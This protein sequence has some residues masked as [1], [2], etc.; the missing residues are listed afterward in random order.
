M[1]LKSDIQSAITGD[2]IDDPQTLLTYSKDASIFEITPQI[3]ICPKD[4]ADIKAVIKLV[5]QNPNQHCS[6]TVRA[7]GTDMG[8]GAINDSIILD[9]KY[10]NKIIKVGDNGA[11]TQPGVFYKDFENQTLAQDLLLP[12][13]TAS[14]ELNT[15]GGMVA[16]NSAGEKTLLYGQTEKYV[17]SLK[18]VL[19]DGEEYTFKPLDKKN[20]KTKLAQTDFEGEI[21]RKIYQL[22]DK[23]YDLIKSAKPIVSKNSTGYL[24]W[25]VW[26]KTTFDLS[27]LFVGS[28]GTLGIITEITFRLTHPKKHSRMLVIFMKDLGELAEVVNCI[29]EFQPESFEAYDDNTLKVVARFLPEVLKVFKASNLLSL[30]VSFLPEMWMSITGGFPKLVLL[31]EFTGNSEPEVLTKCQAAQTALKRY[32]LQ[33]RITSSPDDSKKYWTIRRESFNLLRHHSL[34]FKTAPFID[35]IIVNPKDL[36]V[37]LPALR[38]IL[39]QYN[40][41]YTIAT[42]IGNGNFHIIPLMNFSDPKTKQVIPELGQ[43]VY[44]LVFKFK[45]SMSAEHNDGLVRGPYLKQMY[46][47]PMFNL[48]KEIKDIFDPRNIFNPHKKVD[49]SLEYS[50]SHLSKS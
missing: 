12:S 34:G 47:E 21:Y 14:R 9:T 4:P 35:D 50:M 43:K 40:L 15:V 19:S 30:L 33:T 22:V 42:H 39:D 8:G 27:K 1:D 38:Q 18:A 31:A 28:Q 20:L 10:L 26:D 41:I 11:T 29:L 48:F 23:N 32:E 5:N 24:A 16:N 37:F 17:K 45:G 25:E 3:V 13:Y 44:D 2:I 49:A 46:G 7:A 6:I 36:T